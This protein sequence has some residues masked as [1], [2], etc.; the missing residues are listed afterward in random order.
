[1]NQ[2]QPK[3]SQF[4]WFILLR[5]LLED[6]NAKERV[7]YKKKVKKK[8][9]EAIREMN[10]QKHKTYLRTLNDKWIICHYH[11]LNINHD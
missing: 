7:E 10:E 9:I 5:K 2:Q 3:K 11:H 4:K 6:V 8:N 1:V